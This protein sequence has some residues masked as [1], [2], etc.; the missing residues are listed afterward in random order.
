MILP[1]KIYRAVCR[2]EEPRWKQIRSEIYRNHGNLPQSIITSH[3]GT[4]QQLFSSTQW[5]G[6]LELLCRIAFIIEQGPRLTNWL[7]HLSR[8]SLGSISG[9]SANQHAPAGHNMIGAVQSKGSWSKT[10]PGENQKQRPD[11]KTRL[12]SE[13]K[14]MAQ[15]TPGWVLS[16]QS[17]SSFSSQEDHTSTMEIWNLFC[18]WDLPTSYG[19][20]FIIMTSGGMIQANM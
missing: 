17:W 1:I 11:S 9:L 18:C 12:G 3:S 2:K 14:S 13:S 8:L 7:F 15:V 20:A 10:I 5:Q 4:T 6:V 19:F 16:K